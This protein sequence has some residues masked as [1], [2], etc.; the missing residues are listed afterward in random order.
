MAKKVR[1]RRRDTLP[2]IKTIIRTFHLLP[3]FGPAIVGDPS[4]GIAGA[5]NWVQQGDPQKAVDELYKVLV[6]T[7]TGYNL[8]TSNFQF[9]G[10]YPFK[11]Y[12]AHAGIEIAGWMAGKFAGKS[13]GI[14]KFL[15]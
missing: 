4:A 11:T 2:S 13:L 5:M 3:A 15:K 6:L 8:N 7:Y 14:L 1:H 10:G 12:I 9:E